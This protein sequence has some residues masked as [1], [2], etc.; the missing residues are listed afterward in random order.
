MKPKLKNYPI[1]QSNHG[2][3]I[4]DVMRTVEEIDNMCHPRCSECH[5]P[6]TEDEIFILEAQGIKMSKDEIVCFIGKNG[7]GK[8]NCQDSLMQQKLDERKHPDSK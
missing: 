2:A 8:R 6:L 7:R 5:R 1:S 3:F 4:L